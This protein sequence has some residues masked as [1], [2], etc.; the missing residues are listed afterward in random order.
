MKRAILCLTFLVSNLVASP[1]FTEEEKVELGN[2]AMHEIM[3]KIWTEAMQAKAAYNEG[4]FN[5]R[6]EYLENVCSTAPEALNFHM[7]ADVSSE[8]AS[9]DP[10]AS[11]YISW[12]GQST[13]DNHVASPLNSDEIGPGY[14]NTWG[15]VIPSLGTSTDWYLA[16]T[17]N[18]E[19][20]GYD[21]GTLIL[22]GSPHN[23]NQYFPLSD[24]MYGLLAE[25]ASGDA[26]SDQDILSIKASY[27]DDGVLDEEGD[28]NGAERFY[29][30]MEIAGGCC[31]TGGLFGPWFLY[32]LG[33]VNPDSEAS[34][35][36]AIG[37]GDGGFGQL[38]PGLYKISGDLSTGEI[39]GFDAMTDDIDY[40]VS[41][42]FMQA[43]ALMSHITNDSDWGEWP[44]SVNGFIALGVTVEAGLSGV[45][46]V[47][48][49]I[50]NPGE[51]SS[52]TSVTTSTPL[53]PA[54]TVT[55]KAIKPLTE[56]GH[57]PQSGSFVICDIKAPA[58]MK[59]PD[60]L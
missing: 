23:A 18:S 8:L 35:A 36:Y 30:S 33:I 7:H 52:I 48:D 58:C 20:L 10:T 32:G 13:W 57:S 1:N 26:S 17:V 21:Y 12:D 14:E 2:Q 5:T 37:Y 47:T 54:S 60:T 46:V 16:G 6:E 50:N 59:S 15:L 11:V 49:V 53:K 40:N 29:V 44:N 39:S 34:V 42:D 9:G 3:Q 43:G 24:N 41:G 55:P 27:Y 28:G 19:A 25:D 51:V 56:F 22:S 31:E 38:Y 4:V 45:E